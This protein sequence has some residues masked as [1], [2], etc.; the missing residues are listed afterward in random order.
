[1]LYAFHCRARNKPE[2]KTILYNIS[3]INN[4]FHKLLVHLKSKSNV[5]VKCVANLFHYNIFI[6]ANESVRN[7]WALKKKL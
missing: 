3:Y 7:Y 4:K 6:T 2:N 1:M 5:F